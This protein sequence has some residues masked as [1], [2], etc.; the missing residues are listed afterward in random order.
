MGIKGEGR[1]VS[2]GE[3]LSWGVRKRCC[4]VKRGMGYVRLVRVKMMVLKAKL[5]EGVEGGEG[6]RGL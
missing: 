2:E 4:V 6:W 1:Y 5:W 3:A